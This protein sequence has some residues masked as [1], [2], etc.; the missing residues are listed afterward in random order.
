MVAVGDNFNLPHLFVWVY[1]GLTKHTHAV[2]S[3]GRFF[4]DS[5]QYQH[6]TPER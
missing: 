1:I 3:M 6:T 4:K 2:T 5:F